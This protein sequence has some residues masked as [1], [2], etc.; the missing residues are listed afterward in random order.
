LPWRQASSTATGENTFQTAVFARLRVGSCL[1]QV[2]TSRIDLVSCSDPH[3]DEI[4]GVHDLT[5]GYPTTPTYD[6]IDQLH[7]QRC[8][9]DAR[10]WTGGDDQ[11]YTTGYLWRYEDGIP[12]QAVR[13]FVCTARLAGHSPF[14]GTLRH[15]TR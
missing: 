4:T 3:T 5:A 15:A 11:Q 8:P 2:T 13:V 9:T 6:Q 14:T 7:E 10:D 12:G 1:S